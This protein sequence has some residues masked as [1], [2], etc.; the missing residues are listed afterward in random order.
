MKPET[1]A[2]R[3]Y[4]L[5]GDWRLISLTVSTVQ[6]NSGGTAGFALAKRG[7]VDMPRRGYI[8]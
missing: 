3:Y 1:F 8:L 6:N 5:M 4:G 7:E 2:E